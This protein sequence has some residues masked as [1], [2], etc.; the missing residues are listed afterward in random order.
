MS[1]TESIKKNL[2]LVL[3]SREF[4]KS[5]RVQQFLRFVVEFHLANPKL[6]MSSYEIAIQCFDRHK[7]IDTPVFHFK[8]ELRLLGIFG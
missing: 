5:G 4:T 3:A 2:E 8:V 7:S 6:R 1:D